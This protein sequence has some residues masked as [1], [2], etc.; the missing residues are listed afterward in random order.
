MDDETKVKMME[1]LAKGGMSVGQLIVENTGSIT[2]NDH[3]G[4]KQEDKPKEQVSREVMGRAI[5]AVQGLFWGQSAHAVI[6]CAMR[7]CYDY[8]DNAC[9]YEADVEELTKEMDFDYPCPPNTI[10]SSFHN[11]DYL[12][13]NVDKWEQNNVKQRSIRLLK[14]FQNAV[15]EELSKQKF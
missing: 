3:R 13:L 6:F 2:Y 9:Q 11:N 10:S 1:A 8:E 7:D 5:K 15:C 12:K 4:H 14:A